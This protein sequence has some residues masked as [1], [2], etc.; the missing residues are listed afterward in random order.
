MQ[1]RSNRD[2]PRPPK[3]VTLWVKDDG[4]PIHTVYDPN[5]RRVRYVP[6]SRGTAKALAV[7]VRALRKILKLNEV[8]A[9]RQVIPLFENRQYEIAHRALTVMRL[10]HHRIAK[11]AACPTAI[12]R[13][14]GRKS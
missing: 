10:R 2:K 3:P 4:T 12:R 13:I 8:V 5:L 14:T 6:A 7:A 9:G 11:R 1:G